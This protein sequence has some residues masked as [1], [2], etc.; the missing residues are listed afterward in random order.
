MIFC[1]SQQKN[2][3][4]GISDHNLH[5]QTDVEL[6]RITQEDGNCESVP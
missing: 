1:G 5:W 4:E 2:P 3:Q 6:K